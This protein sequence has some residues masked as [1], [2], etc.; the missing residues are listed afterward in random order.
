MDEHATPVPNSGDSVPA[1]PRPVASNHEVMAQGEN[2]LAGQEAVKARE[3]REDREAAIS[4]FVIDN[5]CLG[6]DWEKA[7]I[8]DNVIKILCDQESQKR[9]AKPDYDITKKPLVL[10][11]RIV[12]RELGESQEV[13]SELKREEVT[14]QT[15]ETSE[16][17][18]EQ[19]KEDV[20]KEQSYAEFVNGLQ[21]STVEK[22][23]QIA[24][25]QNEAVPKEQQENARGYLRIIG[26]A[27]TPQDRQVIT[28]K[29]NQNIN[30]SRGISSPVS[31]IHSQILGSPA[32]TGVSEQ[33]QEAIAKSFGITPRKHSISNGTDIQKAMTE[34]RGTKTVVK[35]RKVWDEETKSYKIVK[36]EVEQPLEYDKE[37]PLEFRPGVSAYTTPTGETKLRVQSQRNT[38][39]TDVTGWMAQDITALAEEM[40]L[41]SMMENAGVTGFAEDVY[42]INFSFFNSNFDPSVLRQNRKTINALFG[43]M[44][45]SDGDIFRSSEYKTL[46][47]SQ[48]RLLTG[49][50]Q[51]LGAGGMLG[52]YDPDKT[53]RQVRA[54]GIQND[55]GKVDDEVLE[56]F[57]SL[58][59]SNLLT[60]KLTFE[61][62]QKELF[63]R[64]PDRVARPE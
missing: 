56:A 10:V 52:A 27:Q 18:V 38:V 13:S 1:R 43:G 8:P 40:E 12:K 6:Y 48:A 46:L 39:E 45:G 30:P 60:G 7:G 3:S 58:T 50:G 32:Q 35:E 29:I 42:K 21:G 44:E 51:A 49:S 4:Q 31:F 19:T 20:K 15:E 64:F 14:E 47:I 36:E 33:S 61:A 23:Q 53:R 28:Q 22:L 16:K 37:N 59:Q 26:L 34:G 5:N 11:K 62:V 25:S 57:G 54:L 24:N 41:W 55:S 2:R 9:T 17:D 63:E